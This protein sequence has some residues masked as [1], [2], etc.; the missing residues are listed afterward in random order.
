M[1]EFEDIQTATAAKTELHGCDIY[2]GSCTLKVEFATTD[3]LNVKRN[4]DMT[5]D[6]TDEC[7]LRQGFGQEEGEIQRGHG[8]TIGLLT[9][10]EGKPILEIEFP[11]HGRDMRLRVLLQTKDGRMEIGGI[12]PWALCQSLGKELTKSDKE[13]TLEITH[14]R[15]VEGKYTLALS[16]ADQ[17]L[18]RVNVDSQI[19]RNLTDIKLNNYYIKNVIVLNKP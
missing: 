9:T 11:Q 6:F 12:G 2:A 13:I 14:E 8:G 1:V 4:D 16:V 5:W 3:R 19:L 7:V 10:I 18:T 17:V 15:D